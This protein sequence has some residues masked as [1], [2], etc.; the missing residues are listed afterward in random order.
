VCLLALVIAFCSLRWNWAKGL[1][2]TCAFIVVQFW[3]LGLYSW[4]DGCPGLLNS[5]VTS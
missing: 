3:T 1:F 5:M 2:K 4:V